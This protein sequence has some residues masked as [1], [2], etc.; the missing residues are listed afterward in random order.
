MVPGFDWIP[1]GLRHSY[2][3]YWNSLHKDMARLKEMMGNSER[4]NRKFYY[5]PQPTSI[6]K[7][8]WASHSRHRRQDHAA[9]AFS[10]DL[11]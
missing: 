2:A 11:K 5:H 3:T 10:D 6:A 7:K 4:V 8:Y 1:D 9:P